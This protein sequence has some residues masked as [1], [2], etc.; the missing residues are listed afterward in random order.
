MLERR[1][2][3]MAAWQDYAGGTDPILSD[4][5]FIKETVGVQ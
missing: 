5:L 3:V 2:P 1:R 4:L